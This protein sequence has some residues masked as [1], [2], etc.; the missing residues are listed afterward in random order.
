V[1][2]DKSSR[3]IWWRPVL[4][5]ALSFGVLA[6]LFFV[7]RNSG[8][9]RPVTEKVAPEMEKEIWQELSKS[10]KEESLSEEPSIWNWDDGG[11]LTKLKQKPDHLGFR[12]TDMTGERRVYQVDH[13]GASYAL[14]AND[15]MQVTWGLIQIK[16]GPE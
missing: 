13:G 1:L 5:F 8:Y 12:M 4:G 3:F 2:E 15:H 11:T 7:F 6:A 14:R 16:E 9:L 10:W